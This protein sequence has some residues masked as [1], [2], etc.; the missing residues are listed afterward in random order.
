MRERVI[1]IALGQKRISLLDKQID[2][3]AQTFLDLGP[4]L[5]NILQGDAQKAI[6]LQIVFLIQIQLGLTAIGGPYKR[7]DLFR[8]DDGILGQLKIYRQGLV[9]ISRVGQTLS[10]SDLIRHNPFHG[11]A[12]RHFIR[13]SRVGVKE[14]NVIMPG[15]VGIAN[16]VQLAHD[17][18]VDHFRHQVGSGDLSEDG[19]QIEQLSLKVTNGRGFQE[20]GFVDFGQF[21]IGLG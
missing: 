16:L 14:V 7:V 21:K 10:I 17:A 5:R 15:S 13:I 2:D 8:S 11:L 19:I 1:K 9:E 4:L 12:G 20:S 6:R 18:A 3:L